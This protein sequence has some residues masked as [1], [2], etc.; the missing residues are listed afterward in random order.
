MFLHIQQFVTGHVYGQCATV[1]YRKNVLY[2]H[3]M[4]RCSFLCMQAAYHVLETP[5][6]HPPQRGSCCLAAWG[7]HF[8]LMLL[9]SNSGCTLIHLEEE[10][11]SSITSSVP[12]TTTCRTWWSNF[13]EALIYIHMCKHTQTHIHVWL[14]ILYIYHIPWSIHCTVCKLSDGICVHECYSMGLGGVTQ[15]SIDCMCTLLHPATKWDS[16]LY[17]RASAYIVHHKHYIQAVVITKDLHTRPHSIQ[18]DTHMCI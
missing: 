7:P 9:D 2:V 18:P 12:A 16:T 13:R 1:E 3:W 17:R 4:H 15:A 11:A 5:P 6:G 8:G 10:L 14:Y